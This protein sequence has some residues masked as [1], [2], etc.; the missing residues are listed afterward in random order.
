MIVNY[1]IM[2]R[3]SNIMGK[4]ALITNESRKDNEVLPSLNQDPL[5]FNIY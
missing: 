3:A 5:T 4:V 1:V 2:L